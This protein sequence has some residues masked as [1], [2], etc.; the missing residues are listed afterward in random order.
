MMI[1]TWTKNANDQYEVATKEHLLQLMQRGSLYTDAGDWPPDYWGSSYLQVADID[2]QNDHASIVPIGNASVKFQGEY[3]GGLFDIRNWAHTASGVTDVGLFGCCSGATVKQ[4]RLAGVWTILRG[5]NAGFLAGKESYSVFRDIEGDFSEGTNIGGEDVT[6]C[7]CLIGSS[8]DGSLLGATIRGKVTFASGMPKWSGGL[9]GWGDWSTLSGCRNLA[10]FLTPIGGE[11]AGGLVGH[12]PFCSFTNC[13][14]GMNGS[15]V[16]SGSA[17]GISGLMFLSLEMD[18]VVNSMTG[19]ITGPKAGGIAGS[20]TN[21]DNRWLTATRLLNYMH[22]DIQGTEASGGIFGSM[23]GT[24][25]MVIVKSVVAMQGSVSQSVRGTETKSL[26][27]AE[28]TVDTSFGMSYTGNVYGSATM[29]VDDEFMYHPSFTDL[30]YLKVEG[31]DWDFL[32]ANVGGKYPDYTHL[33]VHTNHVHAPFFTD[34]GLG[35]GNTVVYLT[36]ANLDT[37]TV[38]H[39]ASLAIV[40]TEASNVVALPA[41]KADFFNAEENVY[42]MSKA[43]VNVLSTANDMFNTGDA[44]AVAVNQSIAKTTFVKRGASIGV[45]GLTSLF[46]PFDAAVADSQTAILVLSDDSSVD[47]SMDQGSGKI[48]VGEKAYGSGDYFVMNNNKV[49]VFDI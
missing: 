12:G 36:Y 1:V 4:I 5:D 46:L 38:Y 11:N 45:D 14:N 33:S 31:T 40:D 22:G 13:L 21:Y 26:S 15:I 19:N 9:I 3:D 17:G 16:A 23:F 20:I 41:S 8:A 18:S 39:N 29:V 35:G 42:D 25:R 44:V 24:G 43:G 32:F 48:Q 34:F 7:G 27:Q 30:P 2:L 47:V 10:T 28:V 6:C 49:K 37:A